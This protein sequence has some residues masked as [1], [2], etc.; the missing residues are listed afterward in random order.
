MLG[1]KGGGMGRGESSRVVSIARAL[2][3]AVRHTTATAANRTIRFS[4]L[5]ISLISDVS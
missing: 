4:I 2:A 5:E 3:L 1:G